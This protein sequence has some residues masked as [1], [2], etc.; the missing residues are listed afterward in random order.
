MKNY[1]YIYYNDGTKEGVSIVKADSIDEAADLAKD[2][3]VLE[4]P[5]GAVRVY[6]TMPM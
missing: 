3:P 5:K 1:V 4:E 2:C 6:E